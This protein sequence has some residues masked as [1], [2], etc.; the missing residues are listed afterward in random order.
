M[1]LEEGATA[2]F[3]LRITPD[4]M[5]RFAQLSGDLNPVHSDFTLTRHHGFQGPLVYGGLLL[6][7][8]SR[9]LGM[10]LPGPGCLWHSISLKFNA[11][12]YVSQ[13]AKVKGIMTYANNELKIFRVKIEIHREAQLI[14]SGEAQ[15][16]F[17][18]LDLDPKSPKA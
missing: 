4:D 1:T 10:Q 8:V 7:A 15:G 12:L 5:Q 6:S 18:N 9:L 14:A 17:L 11:P 2:E 16:T 3:E 13:L